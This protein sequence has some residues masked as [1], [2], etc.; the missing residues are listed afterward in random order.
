MATPLQ[1]ALTI[2]GI[3]K[4]SVLFTAVAPSTSDQFLMVKNMKPSEEAD[5]I[6]DEGYRGLMTKTFGE[7]QGFRQ[8]KWAFDAFAYPIPL[9]T[10]FM[11]IFGTD[12]WASGTTHPFTV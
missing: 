6:L 4:E 8:A 2:V 10:L 7:F 3:A 1:T 11:G 12:G 9:G 5:M